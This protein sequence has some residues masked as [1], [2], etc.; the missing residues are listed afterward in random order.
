MK[1]AY[2]KAALAGLLV[3]I[4]GHAFDYNAQRK[5]T[6]DRAL[7]SLDQNR[8]AVSGSE[9]LLLSFSQEVPLTELR[10]IVVAT[11]VKLTGVYPCAEGGGVMA[12]DL[13]ADKEP[14]SRLSD[15][16][17]KEGVAV[18]ISKAQE[19]MARLGGGFKFSGHDRYC[20]VDVQGAY[21][22][23]AAFRASLQKRTYMT[24]L[25]TARMRLAA[26]NVVKR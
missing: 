13:D 23:L 1:T 7:V 20:G 2:V 6:A 10:P 24:E 21:E 17:N 11:K 8:R 15:P 14:W 5:Q 16:Q 3:P 26:A 19:Q 12:V 22:Q 18:Q 9:Y 4:L 25:T